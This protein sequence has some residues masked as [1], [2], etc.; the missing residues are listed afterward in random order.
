MNSTAFRVSFGK[1]ASG[2]SRFPALILFLLFGWALRGG[3][4]AN[5][6]TL[7]LTGDLPTPRYDH[8]MVQ[9]G[10]LLYIL[11]GRAPVA[12]DGTIRS[13][14]DQIFGDLFVCDLNVGCV[15]QTVHPDGLPSDWNVYGQTTVADESG[16]YLFGGVVE[17][18]G[19]RKV[20]NDLWRYDSSTGRFARIEPQGEWP[21]ARV[22]AGAIRDVTSTMAGPASFYLMGGASLIVDATQTLTTLDDA[23]YFNGSTWRFAKR[24]N[25]P[26]G[27]RYGHGL[28]QDS[29]SLYLIGGNND[30]GPQYEILRCAKSNGSWGWTAS[31]NN[32]PPAA[33][34]PVIQS[35]TNMSCLRF[36]G[37]GYPSSGARGVEQDGF[38]ITILGEVWQF[39]LTTLIWKRLADI[40][41]VAHTAAVLL[42]GGEQG[43][44]D[45][46]LLFGGLRADDQPVNEF[47]LASPS[48]EGATPTPTETEIAETP[49]PTVTPP[50]SI[51]WDRNGDGKIDEKDLLIWVGDIRSST[52]DFDDLFEFSLLW[53]PEAEE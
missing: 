16:F 42:P 22:Y 36:G 52:P 38:D 15:T 29:T 10:D 7:T 33:F 48:E 37:Y 4:A 13:V 53:G 1:K 20:S 24:P 50:P 14:T 21:P 6:E 30:S 49:T 26:Q 39:D 32:P 11:G 41:P 28:V 35:V 43:T 23:W 5:Y 3:A 34:A 25:M 51:S 40:P 45:R 44:S 12:G 27:G 9:V 31:M 47:G 17:T 19:V 2:W 46:F 8:S 18:Q